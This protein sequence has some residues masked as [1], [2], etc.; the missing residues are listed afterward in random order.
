MSQ[1]LILALAEALRPH[2]GAAFKDTAP[3][4]YG[5]KAAGTPSEHAYLYESG[6]LFGSRY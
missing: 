1:D 4:H 5:Y 3:R 2:L 6:G